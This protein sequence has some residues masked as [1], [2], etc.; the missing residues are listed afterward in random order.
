[1]AKIASR[2]ALEGIKRNFLDVEIPEVGCFRLRELS[3]T[4]RDRFEVSVI[5]EENVTGADGKTQSVRKVE[6]MLLRARLVAL[7]LVG[8][9]GKRLYADDEVEILSDAVPSSVLGR[10]FE[11]AQ[12]L[13]G[14]DAAA[15][16]A[17]GKNSES[18]PTGASISA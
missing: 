1:M 6:A 4:E 13:N 10:L 18:A 17:A 2:A 15:Q 7:S 11:A 14:L 9:D 5:H 8:E 3:G 16:E 12:K